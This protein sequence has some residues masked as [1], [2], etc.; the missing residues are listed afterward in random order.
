MVA[1]AQRFMQGETVTQ[2]T[3]H[4]RDAQVQAAVAKLLL[5]VCAHLLITSLE[6]MGVLSRE[7]VSELHAYL[8][9]RHMA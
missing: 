2:A 1:A 6:P 7:Q 4:I 3:A 5:Y 8:R 9:E